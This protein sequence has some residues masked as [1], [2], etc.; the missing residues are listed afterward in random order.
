[1]KL[2]IICSEKTN[3]QPKKNSFEIKTDTRFANTKF[4]P[5]LLNKR[6]V[7][8]VCGKDCIWCRENIILILKIVLLKL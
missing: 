5:H 2:L 6:A 4:I 3:K 1:M 7:C 8:T